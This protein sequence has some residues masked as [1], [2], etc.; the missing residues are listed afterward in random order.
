MSRT[1]MEWDPEKVAQIN[2]PMDK[3]S[4]QSVKTSLYRYK[5]WLI[6][7]CIKYQYTMD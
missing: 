2:L 3:S 6:N 7:K 5:L 1:E 4:E